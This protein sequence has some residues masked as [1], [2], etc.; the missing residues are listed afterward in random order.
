MTFEAF[1]RHFRMAWPR[2]TIDEV[3]GVPEAD[4][5]DPIRHVNLLYYIFPNTIVLYNAGMWQALPGTSPGESTMLFNFF[6]IGDDP[7][8]TPAQQQRFQFA[9]DVTRASPRSTHA[10]SDLSTSFISSLSNESSKLPSAGPLRSRYATPCLNMTI[11]CT[12]G[13]RS[14]VMAGRG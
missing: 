7:T 12:R 4:W 11:R 1:G 6:T 10:A 9:I 8:M 14:F 5:D 2:R 13:R 3:R